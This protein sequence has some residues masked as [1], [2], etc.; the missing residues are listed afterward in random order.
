YMTLRTTNPKQK[1][2]QIE[3]KEQQNKL[4]SGR[5]SLQQRIPVMLLAV[6][7]LIDAPADLPPLPLLNHPAPTFRRGNLAP[8]RCAHAKHTRLAARRQPALVARAHKLD[9][10]L[11]A[12][13]AKEEVA[14]LATREFALHA[15]VALFVRVIGVGG[16]VAAPALRGECHALRE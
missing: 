4:D 3:Q 5:R 10:L 12:H 8:L 14:S 9:A 2:V 7:L 11:V 16:G 13:A 6:A 1:Q 15:R